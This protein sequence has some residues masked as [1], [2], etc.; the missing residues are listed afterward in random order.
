MAAS[1]YRCSA[2]WLALA[3][4]LWQARHDQID[5]VAEYAVTT[6]YSGQSNARDLSA[7]TDR[8]WQAADT[9]G[10]WGDKLDAYLS[11][12]VRLLPG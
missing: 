12:Q 9:D 7:L 4:Q 2:S 11:A 10:W 1:K 8:Y 6:P 3:F 5:A